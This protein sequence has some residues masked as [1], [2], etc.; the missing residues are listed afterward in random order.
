LKHFLEG[1]VMKGNFERWTYVAGASLKEHKRLN[2]EKGTS[3]PGRSGADEHGDDLVFEVA[4][5]PCL[6]E[7]A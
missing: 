1:V 5:L 6:W 7:G 3:D 4:F 2:D